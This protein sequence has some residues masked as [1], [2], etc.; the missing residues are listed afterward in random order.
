[1]GDLVIET[2]G[3]H[4]KFKGHAALAGLDLEVPAGSIY[5]FLGR[6]GAG[7]TTTIKLLMV[8]LKI[9]GGDARV[10]GMPAGNVRMPLRFDSAWAS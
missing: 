1:M 9:D 6:N 5:G 3:L 7:K 10:F 4:K 8:F 2:R